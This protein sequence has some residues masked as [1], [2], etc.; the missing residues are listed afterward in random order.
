[1]PPSNADSSKADAAPRTLPAWAWGVL[2]VLLSLASRAPALLNADATNSD[3]AVVGLQARHILHGELSP[4]LWGSG[5]QTSVDSFAAAAAFAVF[6]PSP[7]TLM[8]TALGLHVAA[9]LAVFVALARARDVGPPRAFVL[10]CFLALTTSAV[11]SYALYPPRQAALTLTLVAFALLVARPAR[12]ALAALLYALALYADPYPLVLAPCALVLTVSAASRTTDRARV[13]R[14]AGIA[15]ATGLVPFVLLRMQPNAKS[16]PLSFSTAALPHNAALLWNECLPWA[17]GAKTYYAQHVMDYAPWNAP[18]WWTAFAT[19]GAASLLP[20]LVGSAWLG[21][22]AAALIRG[23]GTAGRVGVLATLGGFLVSVMVMDHFSMRYLAALVLVLPFALTPL[24]A[25]LSAPR[26]ALA[27]APFLVT[28]AVSGWVGF[29][30][31]V[32]GARPVVAATAADDEA[33]LQALHTRDI[34]YA[35][36]DYWTAYRLGFLARERLIFVPK[37]RLAWCFWPG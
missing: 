6:G 4:F 27:C 23:A 30:P 32:D 31:F 14:D 24:A 34:G 12:A 9:T 5:Y 19:A 11:N 17:L 20:L 7:T 35:M 28:Q 22:A 18:V 15:F 21:R 33:L 16:A 26:F 37:T 25:R 8:M 13:L 36:A 3:A 2:L 10:S 1:M 29:G